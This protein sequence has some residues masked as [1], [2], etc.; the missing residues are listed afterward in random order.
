MR[1]GVAGSRFEAWRGRPSGGPWV[2]AMVLFGDGLARAVE[3]VADRRGAAVPVAGAL[4]FEG[5]AQRI[6]PPVIGGWIVDGGV[7]ACGLA[8]VAVEWAGGRTVRIACAD[9]PDSGPDRLLDANLVPALEAVHAATGVGRRVLRGAV[10]HAVC[11]A[12]LH[13]SWPKPDPADD[14]IRLREVLERFG[15]DS[16]VHHEALLVGDRPWLYAE[17]RSCCLAFRAADHRGATVPFCATCPVV[18]EA[19]RRRSFEA[20]VAAFVQRTVPPS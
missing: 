17:R 9:G 3:E 6:V 5:Y 15:L 7:P 8:D 19:D 4:L 20:A 13:L 11:V 18:P 1:L 14:V 12:F 2:P 10:A 16:L